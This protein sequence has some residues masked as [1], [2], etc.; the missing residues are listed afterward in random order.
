MQDAPP[1]AESRLPDPPAPPPVMIEAPKTSAELVAPAMV[2][3]AP[4]PPPPPPVPPVAA[5]APAASAPALPAVEKGRWWA[6]FTHVLLF[7]TI[8]IFFLG[9][10][11]TFLLWQVLG[12]N[13][14]FIEDQAR[15]ALNFQINVALVSILMAASLIALPLVIVLYAVAGIM[16]LIAARHAARG[17]RYRYPVILRIVSH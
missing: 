11:V 17:E 14:P 6:V 15:E 8:P 16:S 10:T 3:E 2:A 7:A 1:P 12:K 5:A 9:G 4:P 13:D